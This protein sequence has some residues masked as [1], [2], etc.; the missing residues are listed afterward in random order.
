M[1]IPQPLK[2]KLI[3][4]W[5]NVIN[6]KHLVPLPRSPSVSQLLA[7]YLNTKQNN[8]GKLEYDSVVE[9]MK[10]YFDKS[11]GTELLY[12]FE[13]QQ[14]SDVLSNSNNQGKRMSDVY[15]AEH[16]LRLFVKLPELI[17]SV[18]MEEEAVAILT[19]G[20]KDILNK[21]ILFRKI[22]QKEVLLRNF[23]PI[24]RARQIFWRV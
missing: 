4:D 19:Q 22:T 1:N 7:S 13:R 10:A 14:Y 23:G 17:A 6:Q 8:S 15:G 9:C 11:L 3:N 24:F 16:L 5:D 2:L 18:E 21:N 12:K 20:V